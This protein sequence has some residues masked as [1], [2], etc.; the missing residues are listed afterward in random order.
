MPSTDNENVVC[1]TG[2]VNC[3]CKWGFYSP[4]GDVTKNKDCTA[5]LTK[6]VI[7]I[8]FTAGN[9]YK[10]EGGQFKHK[11]GN[12]MTESPTPPTGQENRPAALL[13]IIIIK[14]ITIIIIIKIIKIKITIT[15]ILITKTIKRTKI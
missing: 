2:G 3:S 13:V 7:G 14:I 9:R 15:I 8:E 1:Q 4:S 11:Q 12:W 6:V 10:Y 5:R